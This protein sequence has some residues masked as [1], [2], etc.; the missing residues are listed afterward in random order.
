[1]KIFLGSDHGGFELKKKVAE[2][3]KSKK[4]EIEDMGCEDAE[5][6]DYP[7]FGKKVA[8]K[9]VKTKGSRGIVMCGSGVGIS[10]AANK[11]H[12]ARCVMANSVELATLGR[13]HNG[14]N[15]LAMGERTKFV[16]E[17]LKIVE[18]FLK[19]EEDRSERHVRRRGELNAM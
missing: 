5:S 7:I 2:Y 19:T 16:D 6:C 14:A 15:I 4:Y 3:L 12:G 11:V 10:M 17:P 1:M 18:A 13:A 8:E 9:V